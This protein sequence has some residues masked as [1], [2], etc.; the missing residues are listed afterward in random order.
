[1]PAMPPA[2][3][4]PG[5]I[6]LLAAGVIGGAANALAGGGTFFTFPALLETGLAP[7]SAS[8][9]SAF[10]LWGGRVTAVLPQWRAVSLAQAGVKRRVATALLGGVTGA[11]LLLNTGERQFLFIVPWLLL[12]ATLTFIFSRHI[13]DWLRS[14]LGDGTHAGLGA[15]LELMFAVYGGYFGAGLGVMLLSVY[16]VFTGLSPNQA[17]ALKN[18]VAMLILTIAVAIFAAFGRIVWPAALITLVGALPG[19]WLG[20]VLS[21]RFPPNV[22]RGVIGT[23][24]VMLTGWYFVKVYLL[25]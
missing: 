25:G 24:A 9:T 12:V 22:L 13:G 21:A 6:L 8:A 19:G 11:A 4:I 20:G 1:M 23:A 3:D 7:T 16:A 2:L 15:A 18:L 17:N 5:M 14:R 10:S